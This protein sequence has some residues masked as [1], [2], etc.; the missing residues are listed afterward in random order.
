MKSY[1]LLIIISI[2]FLNIGS[3]HA[4]EVETYKVRIEA[5]WNE[6]TF[7]QVQ[8]LIERSETRYQNSCEFKFILERNDI[9]EPINDPDTES[10]YIE[11][12]T[13]STE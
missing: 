10:D 11:E 2:I 12:E 3:I 13:D 7:V 1:S 6:L 5:V 8:K 9:G 4:A